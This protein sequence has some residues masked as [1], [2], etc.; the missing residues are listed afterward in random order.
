MNKE[1]DFKDITTWS[2]EDLQYEICIKLSDAMDCGI[3]SYNS[4]DPFECLRNDIKHYLEEFER[5]R[6]KH[7]PNGN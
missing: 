3:T 2:D 4:S 1:F 6:P 5:R 7:N